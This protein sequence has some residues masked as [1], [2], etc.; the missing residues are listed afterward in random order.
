MGNKWERKLIFIV[1][2][3]LNIPFLYDVPSMGYSNSVQSS[4]ALGT[5]GSSDSAIA[6]FCHEH[7]FLWHNE[8]TS[9]EGEGRGKA[10]LTQNLYTS[11]VEQSAS[12]SLHIRK[13]YT[14]V[15]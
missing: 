5:P 10:L 8:G 12:H 4:T 15:L 11:G 14:Y 3:T 1:Q 13:L 7:L 6:Y 9:G 2:C